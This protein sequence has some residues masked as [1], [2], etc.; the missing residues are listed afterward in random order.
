MEK[1]DK[2]IFLGG[3][4][5]SLWLNN[6]KKL[7]RN[8]RHGYRVYDSRGLANTLP[9]SSIGGLGGNSGL[10]LVCEVNNEFSNSGR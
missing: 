6:G 9:S 5:S 1:N 2:L 8:F 3:L 4:E 7:S 10:Y